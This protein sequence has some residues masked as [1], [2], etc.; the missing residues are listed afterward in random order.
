MEVDNCGIREALN[1]GIDL[2]NC[3]AA[4][5]A[6]PGGITEANRGAAPME[7]PDGPAGIMEDNAGGA[8]M[9]NRDVPGGPRDVICEALLARATI[10]TRENP[11]PP[12]STFAAMLAD[13][14]RDIT[15]VLAKLNLSRPNWTP[16]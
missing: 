11:G 15:A 16:P 6:A 1:L 14:A 7:N 4:P 12:T 9:A 13:G 3:G 8:P 10:G 5:I 2:V